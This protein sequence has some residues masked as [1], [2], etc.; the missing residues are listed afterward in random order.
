MF[1]LRLYLHSHEAG[2]HGFRSLHWALEGI[3]DCSSGGGNG[4]EYY[5]FACIK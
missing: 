2:R 4:G 1:K 3:H 5:C